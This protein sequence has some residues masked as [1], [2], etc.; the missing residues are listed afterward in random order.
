M[1]QA[2]WISSLANHLWQSTVVVFAAWLLVFALRNNQARIRYWIWLLASL[3]FLIPFSLLIDAGR[4]FGWP[5][6]SV[7]TSRLGGIFDLASSASATTATAFTK[8]APM[9]IAFWIPSFLLLVWLVGAALVALSWWTAW[10]R[11]RTI[12]E[13]SATVENGWEHQLLVRLQKSAGVKITV[14]LAYS[15]LPLEPGVYG[16]CRPTILLP[17]GIRAFL[18]DQHLEALLTHELAHIRRCDNLA[19]LIPMFVQALFW[20][21]PMVWWLGA[22]M[23]EERERACDEE[24]LRFGN[25]PDVYAE[26]ILRVC[27]FCVTC[28]SS[29]VAGVTGSNLKKRVEQIMAHRLG[30]KLNRGKKALLAIAVVAAFAAPIVVGMTEAPGLRAQSLGASADA[31]LRFEVAT[32]KSSKPGSSLKVQFTPSGRVIVNNATLR[33]L[34]KIAYDVGDDQIEGGPAWVNSKRF[35]LEAAPD[36]STIGDPKNMSEDQRRKFREQDRLRLQNLL[37]DRFNLRFRTESK[38]MPIYAMVVAKN[39]PK[40]QQARDAEARSGIV[41]GRGQL[42][43]TNVGMEALAH[44][45]GEQAGKPVLDMTGLK[46]NYNFDMNW[47]PDVNGTSGISAASNTPSVAA[48]SSGPTLFTAVQDQLGLKLEPQKSVAEILIVDRAEK[49]SAN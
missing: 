34:M 19:A 43:A 18:G 24:V 7:H 15:S 9:A 1:L 40:M 35:D 26:S 6:A 23:L 44:F 28:P 12:I 31:N 20:F 29:C 30:Q 17:I 11:A 27:R 14:T 37:A 38:Q 32:I 47:S 33:F 46:G 21:N 3:K 5:F 13:T 16:V 25:S 48:D 42:T 49:P 36:E 45:L 8:P 41:G 22:R 39:G 4:R 2:L 10:R